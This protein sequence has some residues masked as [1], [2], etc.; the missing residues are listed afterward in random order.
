M[1]RDHDVGS[2]QPAAGCHQ[3]FEDRSG[4]GERWIGHDPERLRGETEIRGVG[5]DDDGAAAGERCP[6]VGRSPQVE[7]HCDDAGT[8]FEERSC[9]RTV[10]GADVHDEITRTDPRVGH[11]A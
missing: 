6:Q 1:P 9:E 3:P 2:H 11:E 8:T 4:E 5:H 10:A 7:L